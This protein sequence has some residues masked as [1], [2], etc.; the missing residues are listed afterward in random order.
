MPKVK[1][2]GVR[3]LHTDEPI[4][5]NRDY[6]VMLI[7]ALDGQYLP[8]SHEEEQGEPTYYLKVERIDSLMDLKEHKEVRFEKGKTPSQKLRWR[9][10]EKLGAEEYDGFMDYL[11]GRTDELTDDYLEFIKNYEPN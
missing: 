1:L 3:N 11:L 6:A 2:L 8:E 10:E 5:S 4:K 7:A 9:V